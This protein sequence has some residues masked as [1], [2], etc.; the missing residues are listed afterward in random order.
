[1]LKLYH[2]LPKIPEYL[3]NTTGEFKKKHF[4]DWSERGG[5]KN[6]NV[7]RIEDYF[8]SDDLKKWVADNISPN[9]MRLVHRNSYIDNKI[10]CRYPPHTD[11]KRSTA[12][13]YQT[14]NSGGTIKYWKHK[15]PNYSPGQH[16]KVT[17][18]DMLTEMVSYPTPYNIWYIMDTTVIHS[19]ENLNSDRLSIQLELPDQDP[20]LV[21]FY[22]QVKD[23][24][25]N[26]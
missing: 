6:I 15:D 25:S 11:K 20:I 17:N 10:D 21:D 23:T 4:S 16:F 9:F 12:L 5:D 7:L 22:N 24:N 19:V 8:A 3:L 2:H 26:V 13:I 1:M 14:V 18:Y